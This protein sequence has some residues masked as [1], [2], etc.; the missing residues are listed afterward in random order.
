VDLTADR[1]FVYA[2]A[3]S[4]V[5]LDSGETRLVKDNSVY[6]YRLN[7]RLH[8]GKRLPNANFDAE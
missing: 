7:G 6:S 4:R 2:K 8:C 5:Y 3:D 1:S